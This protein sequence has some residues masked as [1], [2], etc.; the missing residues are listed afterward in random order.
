[1]SNPDALDRL[2]EQVVEKGLTIALIK[3]RVERVRIEAIEISLAEAD[4]LV[5]M[6]TRLSKL[7]AYAL[8]DIGLAVGIKEE[9]TETPKPDQRVMTLIREDSHRH[10]R[11]HPCR[12]CG[13]YF[14]EHRRSDECKGWR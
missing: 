8:E 5:G 6:A 9:K 13:R 14:D 1:M 4:N 7:Y 10:P 12:D 3:A 11:G 2:T